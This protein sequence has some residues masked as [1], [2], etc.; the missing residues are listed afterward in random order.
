MNLIP[1]KKEN[2]KRKGIKKD[3]MQLGRN[4]QGNQNPQH[5]NHHINGT[6]QRNSQ[7]IRK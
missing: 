6:H 5:E 4:M 7:L 3:G 2:D 1:I